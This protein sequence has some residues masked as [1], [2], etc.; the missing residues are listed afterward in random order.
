MINAFSLNR[1]WLQSLI[2]QKKFSEQFIDFTFP[3]IRHHIFESLKDLWII[4]LNMFCLIKCSF[5]S[6]SDNRKFFFPAT[7]ESW[8]SDPKSR[9]IE[10]I[11]L[12]ARIYIPK[13][14][15]M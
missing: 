8:E 2:V 14:L 3:Y 13:I 12:K 6:I 4:D 7:S 9:K 10:A 11:H 1:I 5:Q 15:G